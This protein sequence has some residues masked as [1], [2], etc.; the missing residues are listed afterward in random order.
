MTACPC[1]RKL[2]DDARHHQQKPH[3]DP[4]A[5]IPSQ[6]AS[7][8]ATSQDGLQNRTGSGQV[9]STPRLFGSQPLLSCAYVSALDCGGWPAATSLVLHERKLYTDFRFLSAVYMLFSFFCIAIQREWCVIF[10]EL[11][12]SNR[13]KVGPTKSY[14]R[15]T[16]L[17]LGFNPHLITTSCKRNLMFEFH[18]KKNVWSKGSV[19]Q[20]QNIL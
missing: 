5:K 20:Q 1:K 7:T 10:S 8:L 2:S 3:L 19:T 6:A 18:Y 11:K 4:V 16:S 14:H 9:S 13:M 17:G 15:Y 12:I